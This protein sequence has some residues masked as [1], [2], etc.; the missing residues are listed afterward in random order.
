MLRSR[1][2]EEVR[3][4]LP[5]YAP[6][7]R[8]SAP[9]RFM[10]APSKP[11]HSRSSFYIPKRARSCLNSTCSRAPSGRYVSH[12]VSHAPRGTEKN[13]SVAHPAL[14]HTK[15]RTEETKEAS[16]TSIGLHKQTRRCGSGA[17][18]SLAITTRST[19]R[20][21]HVSYNNPFPTN[22][23]GPRSDFQICKSRINYSPLTDRTGFGRWDGLAGEERTGS[24]SWGRPS[25]EAE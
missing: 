5:H 7:A 20:A 3:R 2:N 21:S 1:K 13:K 24:S 16:S 23:T 17:Y 11:R 19:N 8:S 18:V 15:T 12:F 25:K 14:P 6:E 9:Q 10:R 4:I 22:G